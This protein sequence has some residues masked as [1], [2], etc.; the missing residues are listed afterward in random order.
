MNHQSNF[1]PALA[2]SREIAAVGEP[3]GGR[4]QLDLSGSLSFFRRR[5]LLIGLVMAAVMVVVLVV[6]LFMPKTFRAQ[7]EV[8]LNSNVSA[9]GQ[10]AATQLG[11]NAISN[12]LVETQ[13][14]II[15]SREMAERVS[16]VLNLGD[17]LTEDGR[18]EVVDNLERHVSARRSGDSYALTITYDAASAQSAMT[19]VNTYAQVFTEWELKADQSRNLEARREVESRLS[20]L[21]TQASADTQALQQYRIANNL[22]STSGA[23]LTEQ[24]ISNYDQEVA[25]ARA[26]SAE[27]EARLQTALGQLRAGSNGDDVG[28]ALGSAVIS[29]LRAQESEAATQVATLSA[30]YGANHPELIRAQKQ[31]GEVRQQIQAEIQR[32]V[33]NLRARSQVSD[34]RLASL[35]G[36][37]GSA[38][39]KL[40]ENNAA[41]VGLSELERS[42]AA[43]QSIYETYLNSYKQLLA[44][45][46]SERPS[47]RVLTWAGLPTGPVS[48]NIKLNLV[49]AAVI[50]L[51]LGVVAAYVAEALFQGLSTPEEV[52][53]LTGHRFLA[54]IPLLASIGSAQSH[55]IGEVR[56]AP[57]SVFTEAFRALGASLDQ[58]CHGSAQI[59][60]ITSALPGEGKTVTS[61]CLAHVYA[62]S[63]LRTML[64]DCDLRRAGLS[65]LLKTAG[66]RNGLIEVLKGEA[67]LNF[68]T[69]DEDLSFWILPVLPSDEDSQ[70]LLVGEEFQNLLE[71]LRGKF[72]R[73][74]L[75]LP[76]VLPIAFTRTIAAKADAVV[77]A[78]HWRKTSVFALKAALRRLPADQVHVAGITLNQVDLR[79]RAFF[80]RLDP[81]FY[82][83]EYSEYYR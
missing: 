14:Q 29:S 27:D 43:S 20:K 49:L 38:R 71:Q 33:S 31:L 1:V 44:A 51:G 40:T 50:G 9:A 70:H 82:Y 54:S 73:I 60:A 81:A 79:R 35:S 30:R 39:Q 65:R 37:L 69:A 32:V 19:I 61:C 83:N 2:A 74:V 57:F 12:Q 66:R 41:M 64:I 47:A 5:A 17:G 68:E 63:G 23:S 11:Q 45:E 34:Q 25:R 59:V 56:T 42:A 75:D 8:M 48:P 24:E 22:L 55:A 6:S 77:V 18:R 3:Q 46:G 26:Q 80:G 52:E 62:A 15:T 76:P 53:N 10:V 16:Q 21:R 36:S 67:T 4:D 58:A 28:E 78:A 72:D 13:L 7:S